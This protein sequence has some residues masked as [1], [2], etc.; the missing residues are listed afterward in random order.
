M[1]N[2]CIQSFR[3]AAPLLTMG[4]N[5]KNARLSHG[6]TLSLLANYAGISR[7]LLAQIE[8]GLPTVSVGAIYAVLQQLGMEKDFAGIAAA[9]RPDLEALKIQTS[10]Y[11]MAKA[12][13]Q[14]RFALRNPR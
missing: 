3:D 14:K 7:K 9:Y 12:E 11:F 13:K 5:I 6:F 2:Q 4:E 10:K 1:K 8:M